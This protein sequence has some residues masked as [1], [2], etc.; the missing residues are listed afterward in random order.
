MM[1]FDYMGQQHDYLLEAVLQKLNFDVFVDGKS[2]L[3]RNNLGRFN[4]YPIYK[5]KMS[6]CVCRVYVCMYV[7]HFVLMYIERIM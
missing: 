6:V 5:L 3:L 4:S 1:I 2:G 7:S